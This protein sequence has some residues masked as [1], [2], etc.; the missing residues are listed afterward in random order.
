M[1]RCT[2]HVAPGMLAR[3]VLAPEARKRFAWSVWCALHVIHLLRSAATGREACPSHMDMSAIAGARL[4]GAF[5][6]MRTNF[7]W[8]KAS[9][10]RLRGLYGCY[11]PKYADR[12]PDEL[13]AR[14][15][16]LGCEVAG[17]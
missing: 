1:V 13:R 14:G 2:L 17:V 8:L 9:P 5:G 4:S 16:V 10:M 6:G 11:Q 3:F 15:R 7:Q 12:P